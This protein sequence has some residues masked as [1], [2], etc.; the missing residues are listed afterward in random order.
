MDLKD[1]IGKIV[2]STSSKERYTLYRITAP[3]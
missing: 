2:I 1:F 3:K